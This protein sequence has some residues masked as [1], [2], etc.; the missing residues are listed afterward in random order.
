M[1]SR[2]SWIWTMV[3]GAGHKIVSNISITKLILLSAGGPAPVLMIAHIAGIPVVTCPWK[4]HLFTEVLSALRLQTLVSSS[5]SISCH[6]G[7]LGQQALGSLLA[8]QRAQEQCAGSTGLCSALANPSL[9]SAS[10]FKVIYCHCCLPP[11]QPDVVIA[12]LLVPE[13]ALQQKGNPSCV[14]LGA[15]QFQWPPQALP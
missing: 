12:E 15:L 10:H 7:A 8:L 5:G 3:E 6:R 13:Q 2:V 9:P 11:S 14:S 4:L 1:P